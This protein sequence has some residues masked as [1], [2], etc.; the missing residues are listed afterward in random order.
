MIIFIIDKSTVYINFCKVFIKINCFLLPYPIIVNFTK[1][2]YEMANNILNSN[3]N[4]E[5]RY[6]KISHKA[7]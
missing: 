7:V 4:Q 2:F 5:V 6:E 1:K 3:Q